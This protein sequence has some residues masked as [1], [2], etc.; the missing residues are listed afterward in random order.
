MFRYLIFI[1]IFV[2]GLSMAQVGCGS[3]ELKGFDVTFLEDFT[4]DLDVTSYGP[5]KWIS[6][7]PWYG[8][9][10][11]ARFVDSNGEVFKIE[12]KI[13]SIKAYKNSMGKWESGLLA[14]QSPSKIGFSQKGGYFEACMKMPSGEG[15]WPAFWLGTLDGTDPSIEIDILEFYGHRP[16]KYSVNVHQWLG[17][18][19]LKPTSSHAM[20][21]VGSA[22]VEGFHR[23]GVHLGENLDFYFDRVLM[24]SLPAP[25]EL[26]RQNF[27][28]LL[29]L[30]LGSGWSIEN[31]P[32]PSVLLVA[33]VSA[34]VKKKGAGSEIIGD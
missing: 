30:A 11:D 8:D 15:V 27:L 1:F 18:K 21:E 16:K 33:Y 22:P 28:I 32:N 26:L 29:N 20:V 25:K 6:H 9:F 2:P 12:N 17:D 34:Y 4:G 7:T 19:N 23:Y 24:A 14:S 10:G 13:L 31:T 3:H 5:S